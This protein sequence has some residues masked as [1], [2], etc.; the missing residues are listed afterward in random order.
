MI[1]LPISKFWSILSPKLFLGIVISISICACSSLPATPSPTAIVFPT[2]DT[3]ALVTQIAG[4]LVAQ[5]T[6]S[7]ASQATPSPSATS[8]AT[9]PAL[10]QVSASLTGLPAASPIHTLVARVTSVPAQAFP[11]LFAVVHVT[12]SV[13]ID[14]IAS[15]CPPGYTFQFAGTIAT[16]GPGDVTYNWEFSNGSKT[17]DQILTYTSAATQNVNT[18]WKLGDSG[19]TSGSNPYKGW[20]RIT[21]VKPNQQVF[22]RASFVFR[23]K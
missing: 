13:N 15:D 9:A 10:T 19:N 7:A 3:S 5:F 21:I 23:C 22:P 11:A 20:A 18:S 14:D 4:T 8:L 17:D 12:T 16:N 1:R 2:I 6:Q